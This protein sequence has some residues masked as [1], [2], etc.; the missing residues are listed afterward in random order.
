MPLFWTLYDQQGSS[1]TL[2][3]ASMKMFDMGALGEF[4]PDMMQ[5]VNCVMVLSFIPLFHKVFY[6]QLSRIVLVTPLRKMV[7]GMILCAVAFIVSGLVQVRIQNSHTPMTAAVNQSMVR[8]V[9]TLPYAAISM[10][11]GLNIS[12]ASRSRSEFASFPFGFLVVNMTVLTDT[13]LCTVSVASQGIYSLYSKYFYSLSSFVRFKFLLLSATTS[14][15]PYYA[16]LLSE[17]TTG[18]LRLIIYIYI[19]IFITQSLGMIR[20]SPASW[21][22]N[23]FPLS[24]KVDLRQIYK[25]SMP[26][27]AQYPCQPHLTRLCEMILLL[28]HYLAILRYNK[29]TSIHN[30]FALL[31]AL[32]LFSERHY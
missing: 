2:Q 30:L 7:V 14:I 21:L 23:P 3:A 28:S 15:F 32:I 10:V 22:K 31:L 17:I 24:I 27:T 26:G 4:Q 11:E 25:S 13:L 12:I 29:R 9:N 6:P 1:W 20:L 19:Y 8:F 5:A 18:K 16:T